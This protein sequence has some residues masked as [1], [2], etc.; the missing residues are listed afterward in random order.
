MQ[1]KCVKKKRPRR[2]ACEC[3]LRGPN[4]PRLGRP[5]AAFSFSLPHEPACRVRFSASP[6]SRAP[7]TGV[8]AA[9]APTPGAEAFAGLVA[10][11]KHPPG[12]PT[13]SLPFLLCEAEDPNPNL[14]LFG[15]L[16]PPNFELF[17]TKYRLDIHV[18]LLGPPWCTRCLVSGS[19]NIL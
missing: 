6:L 17:A 7:T 3:A 18:P 8:A 14:R 5:S 9:A 16:M 11:D 2:S 4:N 12:I 10:G 15:Y 1:K 13:P 19:D